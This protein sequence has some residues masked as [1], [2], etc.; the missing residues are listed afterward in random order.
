MNTLLV[1]LGRSLG[2]AVGAF[3][4][5]VGSLESRVLPTAR[6]LADLGGAEDQRLAGPGLVGE[7]PR[8]VVAQPDG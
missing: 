6:R 8:T 5:T 4:A 2:T 7:A 1:G 3:N